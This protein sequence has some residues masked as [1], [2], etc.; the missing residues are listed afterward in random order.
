MSKNDARDTLSDIVHSLKSIFGRYDRATRRKAWKAIENPSGKKLI[1]NL[2]LNPNRPTIGLPRLLKFKEWIKLEWAG[3]HQIRGEYWIQ[4]GIL[5]SEGADGYGD[6][7]HE[8][9]AIYH[10]FSQYVDALVN[11]ADEMELPNELDQYDID[12]EAFTSLLQEILWK[13]EESMDVKQANAYV[14][15]ELECNEEAYSVLNGSGEAKW[16][17]LKYENWI[18]IRSNN[19]ELYG[20]NEKKQ[21]EI[22][23]AIHN[24]L[25][26]EG[27]EGP[28]PSKVD[29]SIDDRKTGR[30]WN[31][32]LE[33]L[34]QPQ[35]QVRPAQQLTTTYNRQFASPKDT[36]EN[37]YS[38][39][40]PGKINPWNVATRKAGLGSDI[41]RGT[42]ESHYES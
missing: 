17:V 3:D 12:T 33:E 32:T 7:N 4:D 35:L 18:A 23:E 39:P 38:N 40:V 30:T 6:N 19:V 5:G 29:L 41:W 13:L 20:Y 24:I 15:Q 21:R 14:M 9:I 25:W 16:Y 26:E 1:N 22:V 2:L 42:S 11:L 37:K 27:N 34:E 8:S 36:E 31:V 28:N 10:I